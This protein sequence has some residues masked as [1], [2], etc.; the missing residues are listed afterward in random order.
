MKE[1][2]QRLKMAWFYLYDILY[3]AKLYKQIRS[4]VAKVECMYVVGLNSLQKGS[5]E[6]FRG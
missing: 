6:F 4:V 2:R 5:K 3:K 1:A